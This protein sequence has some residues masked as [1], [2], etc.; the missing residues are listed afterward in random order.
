MEHKIK[1]CARCG[2]EPEGER[3]GAEGGKGGGDEVAEEV[4]AGAQGDDEAQ[5][6]EGEVE[7]LG[8]D[9]DEDIADGAHFRE[10]EEDEQN[11]N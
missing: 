11:G 8:K 2:K 5:K 6:A 10:E 7:K 3:G 1:G 9:D 4:K